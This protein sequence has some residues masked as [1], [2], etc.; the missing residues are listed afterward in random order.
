MKT[1]K[2]IKL[3]ISALVIAFAVF[4]LFK[5]PENPN[6]VIFSLQ[7][8]LRF[9]S[10]E[11]TDNPSSTLKIATSSIEIKEDKNKALNQVV[12]MTND[13]MQKEKDVDLIVFGEAALGLYYRKENPKAYQQSVAISIPGTETNILS[14]LAK[15][16]N[17]FLAVGV[18]ENANDNIYN[19]LIVFNNNGE[20]IAKHR[21]IFLHQYDVLNG[22]A[23]AKEQVDTCSIKNFKVGLAICADANTHFLVNSYKE[24][25]VDVLLYPVA[26]KMPFILGTTKYWPFSKSYN[27]WI[28]AANRYG[29][30]NGEDYPGDIFISDKN[31]RIHQQSKGSGYIVTTIQK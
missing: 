24:N 31:G 11:K 18:I 16:K 10:I 25:K 27:A 28:V 29:V 21:K 1:K 2:I 17:V 5:K 15:K 26:S 6:I 8:W 12:E 9:P 30:E 4:I 3:S 20:I 14:D 22:I 23:A 7:E 19:S 13:I